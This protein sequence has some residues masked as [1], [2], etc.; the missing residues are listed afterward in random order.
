M[1]DDNAKFNIDMYNYAMK[2]MD[3][4]EAMHEDERRTFSLFF[5]NMTRPLITC[6]S[7]IDVDA[8]LR[9]TIK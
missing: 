6:D 2:Y 4:F 9:E 5:N 3:K 8:I 1:I 7:T